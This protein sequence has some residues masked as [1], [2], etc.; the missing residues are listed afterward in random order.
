MNNMDNVNQF[1]INAL[2]NPEP[3]SVREALQGMIKNLKAVEGGLSALKVADRQF[4][5][6]VLNRLGQ[7]VLDHI[8][9][10]VKAEDLEILEIVTTHKA[11]A[12]K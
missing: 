9:A 10:S 8:K 1:A 2:S 7:N 4:V 6:T 5:A 12:V 3:R 11:R